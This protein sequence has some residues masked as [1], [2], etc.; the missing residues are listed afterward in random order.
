MEQ[1]ASD[2]KACKMKTKT[3]VDL[4]DCYVFP[5]SLLFELKSQMLVKA[6]WTENGSTVRG[7][8]CA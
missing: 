3:T 8:T 5:S 6:W 2:G 1:H 4:L 7:L